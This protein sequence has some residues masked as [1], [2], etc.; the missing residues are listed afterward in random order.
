MDSGLPNTRG[1][2]WKVP[3]QHD[4]AV[5]YQNF[6]IKLLE[7]DSCVGW[8]FFKYQDNDPTD[9]TVDPSNRDSNKGLFNNKYEPYEEFT[10]PVKEFNKRRYAVWRDFHKK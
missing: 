5:H 9:K 1:A 3:S 10:G 4:R 7:S 2:G 6:C 8:N